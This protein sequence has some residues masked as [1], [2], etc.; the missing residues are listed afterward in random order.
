[1]TISPFNS[2][3]L[4][5]MD[6]SHLNILWL[7]GFASSIFIVE[8]TKGVSYLLDTFIDDFIIHMVYFIPGL[9]PKISSFFFSDL[10]REKKSVRNS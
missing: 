3:L 2:F 9:I 1:M 7:P 4:L 8:H 6:R 10:A 5:K